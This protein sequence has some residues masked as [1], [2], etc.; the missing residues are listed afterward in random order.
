MPTR[1]E[2]QLRHAAFYWLVLKSAGDLYKRGGDNVVPAFSAFDVEWNNVSVGQAWA[3]TTAES[4]YAASLYCC[5]YPDVGLYLL[6]LRQHPSARI[7]WLEAAL[8]AA[9]RVGDRDAEMRH[10]GNL[11]RAYFDVGDTSGAVQLSEKALAIA[12]EAGNHR[13]I[14]DALGNLGLG[15]FYLGEVSRARELL[16]NALLIKRETGDCK[17]RRE[18]RPGSAARAAH[19]GGVKVDRRK[20]SMKHSEAGCVVGYRRDVQRGDL[21]ASA[22][23]GLCGGNERTASSAG[24]WVGP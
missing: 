4:D 5:Y 8:A 12:E 3:A 9:R 7:D 11:A 18:T 16:E 21:W 23:S 13:Y 24:V 1:Y 14:G 17:R 22:P 10:L 15:Y 19:P 20:I 6:D 2:A